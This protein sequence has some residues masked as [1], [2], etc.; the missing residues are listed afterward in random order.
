M[1]FIYEFNCRIIVS[2]DILIQVKITDNQCLLFYY[3]SSNVEIFG[4]FL[5]SLHK[6]KL[7]L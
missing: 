4:I 1:K 3:T 5:N 6:V 2:L 7:N